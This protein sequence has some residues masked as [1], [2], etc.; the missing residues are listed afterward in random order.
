MDI[1]MQRHFNQ[2]I[3]NWTVITHKL[4][5]YHWHVRGHQFYMLH[6]QFEQLYQRLI[7]ELDEL[8]ER[9][10]TISG[11]AVA[12]LKEC[13]Q[14]AT[15]TESSGLETANEM[16]TNIASDFQTMTAQL[17]EGIRLAEDAKDR[18]SADLLTKCTANLEK[19]I[20][21]LNAYLGNETGVYVDPHSG[22]PQL[23]SR[24]YET[25]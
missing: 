18:V 23:E 19:D 17:H 4:R 1:S 2:L 6:E 3:G 9:N 11:R 8:A 7:A 10:V 21:M 25:H 20:W 15:I 16:V 13:L 12:N 14:V 22:V 5:N 24:R